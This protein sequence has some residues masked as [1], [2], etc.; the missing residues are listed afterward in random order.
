MTVFAIVSQG[1]AA[2]S[3]RLRQTIAASFPDDFL[4]VTDAVWLV[5]APGSAQDVSNKAG[6][7]Q[8]GNEPAI[9]LEISNYFG[10][11]NPNVWAWIKA[12]W[13]ATSRG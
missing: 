8:G 1:G 7:T 12:K 2:A 9:V 11:S 5:A 13:E 3:D 6:I 4:P 10:R